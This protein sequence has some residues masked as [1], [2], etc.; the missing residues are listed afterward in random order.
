MTTEG[1]VAAPAIAEQGER[2]PLYKPGI[3]DLVF[4]FV[5][6]V[7]LRGAG[8]GLL[9]DP[10]LGW[11]L[12]NI[13]A[14]RASGW[15][16]TEDPFT[17]SRG[18]APARWYSNQWLGELPLYLGWKL[19]GLEGIAIVCALVIALTARC[20]YRLLIQDGLPWPVAVAWTALGTLGTS[21]SWVARPN[22]F[23]I[24]F[25]L[26]T[27]R[28]LE[29]YH[30]GRLTWRGTLWLLPLF[31]A[32][33][34]IHGGFLAGFILLAL[35]GAVQLAIAVG[36]FDADSRH[37]ARRRAL[38]LAFLSVAAFLAT[39]VNPYGLDL[40]RWVFRLLGDA[41]FMNLNQEWKSPDF[42]SAGAMRY[43]LLILL[44]PFILGLS[45]RRL[46][47]L[48]LVL[49]VAWLHLALTGF[50]YVAL[51]AV[52][53]TPVMARASLDIPYLQD[54]ALRWQLSAGPG[55]LFYTRQG[56]APWLWSLLIAV[57]LIGAG[58]AL[59]GQFARHKPDGIIAAPALDR[60]LAVIASW[61]KE[62]GGRSPRIFHAYDWGGYLTWH[63]WPD[64]HN[65]IDDRNEVQGE[66]R[67]REYFAIMA[68]KPGWQ[69]KLATVDLI[70]IPRIAEGD[71]NEE[72]QIDEPPLLLPLANRLGEK[73]D[74]WREIKID[75]DEHGR[76]RRDKAVAIFERI[77][78]H[79]TA[80]QRQ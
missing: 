39:L 1:H 27:A 56:A 37:G 74:T 41:Y 69:G 29:Q 25:V 11:H 49:S 78:P 6:I 2:L 47:L 23:T 35:A 16:L 30:R 3:A 65:W 70:C 33:A 50:R 44:F 55:S 22:L 66:E 21:C 26:L 8:Q 71:E 43:E 67:T 15:F 12:R 57:V 54:L 13:D 45:R 75:R 58:W 42:H 18:E 36:S 63:G 9:D 72:E 53:A 48:E 34:N 32:W 31:A 19:A 38:H 10:G 79:K 60:F 52:I 77:R 80:S 51:W 7:A 20:L 76:P 73:P 5:A 28:V 24:L 68:A 64:V 14:I 61:R 46:G 59:Q 17:D 62:H 4:L 40:Y